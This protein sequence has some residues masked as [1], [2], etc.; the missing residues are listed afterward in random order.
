MYGRYV[1]DMENAEAP[2]SKTMERLQEIANAIHRSVRL[3]ID[4][5]ANHLTTDFLSLTL[6]NGL[7]R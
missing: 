4:Y 7:V 5:S 2:D 1:D 3:T 6:H